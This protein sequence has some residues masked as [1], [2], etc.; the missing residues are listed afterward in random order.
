MGLT[1]KKKK[2]QNKNNKRKGEDGIEGMERERP[3]E[4][5]FI[6]FSLLVYFSDL[7][8]FDRQISSGKTRK[9]LYTTKATRGYQKHGISQIIQV[10]IQKNLNF[11][12]S[13]IYGILTVRI[14]GLRV[15]V[16][17]CD[18]SYAWVPKS[19]DFTRFPHEIVNTYA[20]V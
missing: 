6:Y 8:K 12:F 18:E 5:F 16:T 1:K 2:S 17:L 11:W 7:W 3:K 10:K 4:R 9:V 19:R 13:Q 20:Y 14:F 15:K